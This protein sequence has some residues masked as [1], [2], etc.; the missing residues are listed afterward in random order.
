MRA[1]V[2]TP[3]VYSYD[4]NAVSHLSRRRPCTGA[5]RILVEHSEV[6]GNMRRVICFLLLTLAAG[7]ASPRNV[8]VSPVASHDLASAGP[9]AATQKAYWALFAPQPGPQLEDSVTPLLGSN[10]FQTIFGSTSNLLQEASSIR[11]SSGNLA[12]VLTQPNGPTAPSVLLIF[13][14]P[15]TASSVPLYSDTLEGALVGL[16]IEFDSHGNLWVSSQGNQSVFEY[17]GDFFQQGGSITPSLVLT[18]GLNDPN[19][20]AFDLNGNLY[21]AN[22]GSNDIAVFAQPISNQ[23]PFFLNGV[24][25]PGGITFDSHGN[26]FA[27]S[28]NGAKGS[29]VKYFKDHLRSG[30]K[31]GVVDATGINANPFG[32]DL[33]FDAAGNLYDGDCGN[34]AGIYTYPLATQ[35]FSST[36]APSFYTNRSILKIGCVWGLAIH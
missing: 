11:I 5:D 29:I 25:N 6:H 2:K 4:C 13:Q 17:A 27:A 23:Q 33:A 16:H 34:T 22:A 19:G 3:R 21:V 31:P 10:R 35:K 8:A 26:L 7:C 15:L 24:K 1:T 20:L 30:D 28:N 12:W 9:G 14:L 18:V 32:S 36:L